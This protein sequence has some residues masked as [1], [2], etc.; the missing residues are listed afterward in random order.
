MAYFTY[1]DHQALSNLFTSGNDVQPVYDK[2]VQLHNALHRRFRDHNWDLHPNWHNPALISTISATT[3]TPAEALVLA[4]LRSAEQAQLVERLMGREHRHWNQDSEIYRHPVIELRLT[5]EHF[6]VE[7]VLSPFAWWDQQNFIGKLALPRHREALRAIL[8]KIE[9]DYICGFWDGITLSDMHLTAQQLARGNNL[10]E[11]M[12]TFA[13]G[14]D[15]LR[16]GVWYDADSP[17]LDAGRI[18][19][20]LVQRVSALHKVYEFVLWTSNNDFHNFY[21]KPMRKTAGARI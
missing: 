10:Y 13:D 6:V 15:F 21:G 18:V 16:M 14:Q 9:G 4:Y 7:L 17:A 20:E 5:P 12:S 11:W 19:S 3:S 8:N 1:E 2:F